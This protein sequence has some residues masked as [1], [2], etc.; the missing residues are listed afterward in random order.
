M[1][2]FWLFGTCE[3]GCKH[4]AGQC[5]RAHFRDYWQRLKNGEDGTKSF[6]ATFMDGLI[7]AK[8]TREAAISAW[9]QAYFNYVKTNLR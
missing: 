1:T 6:D 3:A 5:G 2:N 9:Q 4:K 7:K 8:G